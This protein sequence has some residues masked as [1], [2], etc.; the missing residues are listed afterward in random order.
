MSKEYEFTFNLTIPEVHRILEGLEMLAL[1]H[2]TP[3][4]SDIAA[5]VR[6]GILLTRSML[7]DDYGCDPREV[8][9]LTDPDKITTQSWRDGTTHYFRL[10][11]PE[12]VRLLQKRQ[13]S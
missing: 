2:R 6:S 4:C 7:I 11:H 5:K 8:K 12:V 3:E 1:E 13:Q 10:D 9:A